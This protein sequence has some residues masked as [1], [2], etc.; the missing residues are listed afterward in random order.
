MKITMVG[1]LP[2]SVGSV[3]SPFGRHLGLP[4]SERAHIG[5]WLRFLTD[6]GVAGCGCASRSLILSDIVTGRCGRNS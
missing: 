6:A 5:A 4:G 1:V 3:D 2:M